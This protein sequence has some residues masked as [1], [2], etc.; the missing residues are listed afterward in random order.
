MGRKTRKDYL[1]VCLILMA[2][3]LWSCG[4]VGPDTPDYW[5]TQGWKTATPES[6]GMDSALLLDMLEVIWQN[7]IKIDSVLVVR[8]G[9]IVLDAY[10]YPRDAADRHNIY[11]CSKSV[12]SALIGIAIDKGFIKSVHQ[13]VLDFFP[14]HIAQNLDADKEAMTLEHVLTMTT[15]LEC[16]DSFRYR[17]SGLEQMKNSPDWVQYMID[18]PMAHPP[19]THFEYCNGATFLLS[20]ILQQK[21]GT[22]ALAFAQEHLFKPL[23]ISGVSWP[24]NPRGITVGYGQIYMRPRDMAKFGYLYLN[25]GLWEDKQ[26][27]P[28]R[29]I[30]DSTRKHAS[31]RGPMDYGYQWWT[32]GSGAY[33][34]LG[35]YGQF[36]FVVPQKNIVAV[37][38]SLL[39]QKDIFTPS[40]LLHANIIPSVK[41]DKALPENIERQKALQDLITLWQ[42]TSPNDRAEIREKT[43]PAPAG[44]QP[45][46]YVNEAY[47]FSVKY[48]PELTITDHALEPGELFRKKAPEGIPVF[49]VAVADIPRGLALKETGQFLLKLYQK[50]SQVKDA[51]IR[52]QELITL[53]DGTQ[54]NYGEITWRYRSFDLVTVAVGTYKHDKLIGVSVVGSRNMPVEYLAGMVKSLKFEN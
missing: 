11:S 14:E 39:D 5:P 45:G 53:S 27:I 33:T 50:N 15:G 6:Q 2:L 40:T 54:A 36:I 10:C 1:L 25:N 9:Y 42:D 52:K 37:F 20:A 31:T 28:S 21:T 8:N 12:T 13:P 43:G 19:G 41:S 24:S 32:M 7:D 18:L 30:K 3:L 23:G 29:W 47:G 22:N 34:A 49:T 16:R 26:I 46:Q 44:Q 35:Y 48:D 4:V 17:W 51:D 38:T